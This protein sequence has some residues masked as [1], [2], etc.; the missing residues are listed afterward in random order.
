MKNG[1]V[2]FCGGTKPILEMLISIYS[3]KKH[4]KG[5]ITILL[6]ETSIEHISK[7]ELNKL[8]NIKI[9]T[10][11]NSANDDEVRKHWSTRWRAM[12]FVNYDKVLHLD[13]DTVVVKP[14]DN[15]FDHI[16]NDKSYI[17]T[18]DN[19]SNCEYSTWA[20]HLDMY[21]ENDNWFKINHVKPLYIE[22]GLMGWNRGYP[23]FNDVSDMCKKMKDDQT[24][25]S[26]VLIKNGRKGF[27]PKSEN[28]NVI[29][30]TRNYYRLSYDQYFEV[31]VWHLTT[32]KTRYP[33][34]SVWW[35]EFIEA[36]MNNYLG[37]KT[38]KKIIEELQPHVYKA[39]IK[40]N[41][42]INNCFSGHVY[43]LKNSDII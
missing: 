17:T 30:R 19:F 14:I 20:N 11:P 29:R 32:S 2:Y 21:K 24:A 42:P 9:V 36:Y 22:F 31:A 43:L 23:Y 3:L 25:M 10:V 37:F 34:Y 39:M 33:G 40:R 41:Y 35:N 28:F 4:Y 18:F 16:H 15:L 27:S 12:N 26:A 7:L 8:G 13:C 5:E 38:N 1:V 6:G